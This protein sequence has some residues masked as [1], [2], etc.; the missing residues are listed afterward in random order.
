LALDAPKTGDITLMI[1]FD[2]PM[3]DAVVE[4]A[5]ILMYGVIA[6]QDRQYPMIMFAG[7]CAYCKLTCFDDV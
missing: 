4:V 2:V 7:R 6:A 1:T 5:V 3:I